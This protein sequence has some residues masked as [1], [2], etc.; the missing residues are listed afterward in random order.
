MSVFA[1]AC[2]C[3]SAVHV[4]HVNAFERPVMFEKSNVISAVITDSPHKHSSV[5]GGCILIMLM[6][7]RVVWGVLLMNSLITL[8]QSS[9]LN[10]PKVLLPLSAPVPVNVTLTAQS[11]CYTW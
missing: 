8:S 3:V 7:A 5:G 6:K 9:K 10:V 4:T 11:G 1:C 2:H